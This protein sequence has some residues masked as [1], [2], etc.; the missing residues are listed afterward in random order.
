VKVYN[1]CDSSENLYTGQSE[2][3]EA[4]TQNFYFVWV[5]GVLDLGFSSS[6]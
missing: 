2:G 4:P 6:F 3:E 1:T 5:G